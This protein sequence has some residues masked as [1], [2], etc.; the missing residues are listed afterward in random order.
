[1]TYGGIQN[2]S[3]TG[4]IGFAVESGTYTFTTTVVGYI[5]NPASG[6]V[7]VSGGAASKAIAFTAA[8]PGTFDITFTETGL[9]AGTGWS[10]TLDGVLTAS[11]TTQIV[12]T[13]AS[14]TY[15]FIAGV[16]S[17]YTASPS[18]GSV[19]MNGAAA[20]Q[21]I[22]FTSLGGGGGGPPAGGND[23]GGIPTWEWIAIALL[24]LVALGVV[25]AILLS[26]RNRK[27]PA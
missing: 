14:G 17:N 20:S 1:V 10:V 8:L 24:V 23:S 27:K 16:V 2:T 19:T 21:S 9:A 18:T 7:A 25:A 6:S 11:T 13:M 3:T 12:F 26:R 4:T 15:D 5:A 22:T